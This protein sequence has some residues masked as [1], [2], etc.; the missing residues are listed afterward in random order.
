[1]CLYL[2]RLAPFFPSLE[3]TKQTEKV[4]D[5][6]V[7]IIN[8]WKQF[9]LEG[10][11]TAT[12]V[13]NTNRSDLPHIRGSS[14]CAGTSFLY[15]HLLFSTFYSLR[16]YPHEKS[17]VDWITRGSSMIITFSKKSGSMSDVS[18]WESPKDT[19]FTCSRALPCSFA[20]RTRRM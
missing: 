19:S 7:W 14:G 17:G 10:P 18:K 3:R 1:M 9:S 11:A 12:F 15:R 16:I 13:E 4:V 6:F 20:P 2:T 5:I 8:C